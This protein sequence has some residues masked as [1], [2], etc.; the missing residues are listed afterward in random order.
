[1]QPIRPALITMAVAQECTVLERYGLRHALSSTQ[2]YHGDVIGSGGMIVAAQRVLGNRHS[3]AEETAADAFGVTVMNRIGADPQAFT[4]FFERVVRNSKPSSDML[5]LYDHPTNADRI[6][7]VR[8]TPTMVN[9]KPLLTA[10]EWQTLKQVCF[11]NS[12]EHL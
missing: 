4:C 2:P 1:M 3:R 7:A 5:L 9:P 10:E 12:L 8:A 11:G 6:A